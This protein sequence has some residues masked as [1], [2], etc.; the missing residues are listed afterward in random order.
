M[1]FDYSD[2]I[3]EDGHYGIVNSKMVNSNESLFF[4]HDTICPFCNRRIENVAYQ[5]EYTEL[6]DWLNG[7]FMESERVIQCPTCGWWEYKYLN[8]SDA[9]SDGIRASDIIYKSAILKQYENNSMDIPLNSLRTAIIKKPEL[10]CDLNTHKFEDLV[11]SV[12][13]DYYPGCKVYHFGKTRDGG[14]DGLLVDQ[15]GKQF[16]IQVKRREN[17][18]STESVAPIRE[19]IGVSVLEDNISGCIFVSTAAKYS[20]DAISTAKKAIDKNI[21]EKFDLINREDFYK[22]VDITTTSTPRVWEK[23]LVISKDK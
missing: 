18:Y 12:L 5:N 19:L 8:Q 22:Y 16:L 1:I 6:P 4:K 17:P 15:D 11:R 10:L 20:N 7:S 21:V 14:K 13:T 23:L 9:I 3:T 2:Y